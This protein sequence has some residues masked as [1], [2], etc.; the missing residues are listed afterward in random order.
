MT[1]TAKEAC[2]LI[3]SS[4][5]QLVHVCRRGCSSHQR[6]SFLE[7]GVLLS[8]DL[9]GEQREGTWLCIYPMASLLR[10]SLKSVLATLTIVSEKL[11]PC[12]VFLKEYAEGDVLN[13]SVL[14]GRYHEY[15]KELGLF[16]HEQGELCAVTLNS[17]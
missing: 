3:N 8:A 4:S 13:S 2:I 6:E 15:W 11:E 10:F 5:E 9:L 14:E 16:L 12:F 1:P 7:D 17:G